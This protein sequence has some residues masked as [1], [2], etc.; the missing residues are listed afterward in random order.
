VTLDGKELPGRITE[1][2]WTLGAGV[3]TASAAQLA[4]LLVDAERGIT[5]DM[6]RAIAPPGVR[7]VEEGQTEVL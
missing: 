2:H 3:K 5:A 6:L 7:I 1:S 4:L